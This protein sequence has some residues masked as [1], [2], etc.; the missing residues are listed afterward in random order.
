GRSRP[1]RGCRAKP[2][3]RRQSPEEPARAAVAGM[4]TGRARGGSSAPDPG[5]LR[6]L[7]LAQGQ[8]RA[9]AVARLQRQLRIVAGEGVELARQLLHLRGDVAHG[10]VGQ[11]AGKEVEAVLR[12]R[13]RRGEEL[14]QDP[15]QE[16]A[17]HRAVAPPGEVA[18]GQL[19][20]PVRRLVVDDLQRVQAQQQRD[21]LYVGKYSRFNPVYGEGFLRAWHRAGLLHF[22]GHRDGEGRLQAIAG[23]FGHGRVVTT[24]ILG[25]DT[26]L[27]RELGL[28]RL[29]AINVY[30]HAAAHGL[31]VNLSAGAA[32]FK[33]LRGGR[34]AIE[35]SAVYARH[36]PARAQRALDLLSAASCRLGAPLLRR[37]AL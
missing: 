6:V 16:E 36:L 5:E 17:V 21:L 18:R 11:H 19:A 10:A 25:Y 4:R 31:E 33:R 29:A 3:C 1:P 34:P 27:P 8:H 14:R 26:G 15:L 37:F 24:P 23:V 7:P 2:C 9:A 22:P 32:G 13:E 12:L 30:R 35:Y 28:Y 20:D